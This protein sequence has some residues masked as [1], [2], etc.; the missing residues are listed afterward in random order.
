VPPLPF[1]NRTVKQKSANDS[2]LPLAKVGHRQT[3]IP[4]PLQPK[5][6]GVSAFLDRENIKNK[7]S[8]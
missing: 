7:I 8:R 1:P 3:P 5:L 2:E 6:K 4:N